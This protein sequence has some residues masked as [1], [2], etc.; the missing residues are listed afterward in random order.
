MAALGS[1]RDIFATNPT[2]E[3]EEFSLKL[4]NGATL[5]GISYIPA[6]RG[7]A[8]SATRPLVVGIHGAS[9]SAYV[10]DVS[11]EY[12]ASKYSML[13]N[14][15][16][17]AFNRPNYLGSSGRLVDR[18]SEASATPQFE[19]KEGEALVQ[20]EARWYHELIFPALWEE[21][22]VPNH[23]SSIVT[24]SHSMAVPPTIIASGLYS[25]SRPSEGYVWAGMVLSG[26][27]EVNN[28]TFLSVSGN[29][30]TN[31]YTPDQLPYGQD[32]KI[33]TPPYLERDKQEL[34][35]G[36]PGLCDN[37]LRPLIWKQQTPLLQQEVFDMFG[38]WIQEKARYKAAVKI[39]VLNGLGEF[40]YIWNG[41][42]E[43]ADSFCSDFTSCPRLESA[44][45]EGA[46]HAIELSRAG[47]G[48]W[49]RVF[50]WAIEVGIGN[51]M[52]SSKPPKYD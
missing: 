25:A 30:A 3:F 47:G 16:F 51:A 40:D 2:S 6:Q 41:T 31:E 5:T 22:A 44:V 7:V 37:D 1:F 49:M 27:A 20:E 4:S 48:W 12:T 8:G 19:A 46:P 26:F 39:P 17:L 45:V 43:N 33:H 11:P 28:N 21:F 9:C 36:P 23:C 24:T 29:L 32:S 50:G 13:S 52:R 10:Y 18:S 15:P 42:K 35:L 38:I 34:M 14:V